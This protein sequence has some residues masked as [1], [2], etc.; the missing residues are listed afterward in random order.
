MTCCYMVYDKY[1]LVKQC[2]KNSV[3]KVSVLGVVFEYCK[4]HKPYLNNVIR[5]IRNTNLR[6]NNY[7]AHKKLEIS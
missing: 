6:F 3:I 1:S 2:N 4:K 5:K 7:E